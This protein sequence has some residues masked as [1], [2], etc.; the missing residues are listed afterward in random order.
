MTSE[1]VTLPQLLNGITEVV[2]T[3]R[4][5]LAERERA[6]D[7][8]ADRLRADLREYDEAT[9]SRLFSAVTELRTALIIENRENYQNALKQLRPWLIALTTLFTIQTVLLLTL[10][11]KR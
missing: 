10:W 2:D 6:S 7:R 9:R 1:L 3:L 5:H 11:L 4:G 8:L